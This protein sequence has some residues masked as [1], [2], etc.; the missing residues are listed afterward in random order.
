MKINIYHLFAPAPRLEMGE[1][2]RPTSL[3]GSLMTIPKRPRRSFAIGSVDGTTLLPTFAVRK[4]A[5]KAKEI[6]EQHRIGPV[7]QELIP[8]GFPLFATV[9]H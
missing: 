9:S 8:E 2:V 5:W 4:V 3:V 7:L 6:D 1:Q